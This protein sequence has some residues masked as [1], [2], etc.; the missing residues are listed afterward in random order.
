MHNG[1]F[2][3]RPDRGDCGS[4]HRL[5][6]AFEVST[7]D[8]KAHGLTTYPLMGR[9]AAVEC[10]DCHPRKNN[11]ANYHPGFASCTDCHKD[12]HNGQFASR[13]DKGACDSCHT[14]ERTFE[15]STFDVSAHALTSYPLAGR[16]AAVECRN[17]HTVNRGIADYH[18]RFGACTDCH[19]DSHAGQFTE[20]FADK[21]ETCHVLDGFRPS[22]FTLARHQQARFDLRGAHVAIACT[23]CHK[24]AD[25]R[26]PHQYVFDR[27]T[28]VACHRD[29]HGLD[30][31][32]QQCDSC[33]TLS[34][35]TPARNF[36]HSRTPFSLVG[37]HRAVDC[38]ACH[39][40]KTAGG[41]RKVEFGG[42]AKECSGCHEDVHAGQFAHRTDADGC[43]SCH[44]AAR[45]KPAAGFS[46]AATAFPLDGAH[47]NVRCVL[48]HSK[49]TRINQRETLVFRDAP[50]E[51]KACH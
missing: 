37:A 7:F 28:C 21:C 12:E 41:E 49:T 36:D 27:Q 11:L 17:C 22:T 25:D 47:Q 44:T 39:K 14:L 45:W 26:S 4:C 34:A 48:C 8:V 1:Q 18:P 38:L 19:K 35:W 46:H 24:K 16:H 23:D 13:A 6:K 5:D 30:A 3:S 51:C 43:D 29:P 50:R 42:A 2:A 20:R 33:H 40:P 32:Q 15:H 31:Q 10:K 9:H